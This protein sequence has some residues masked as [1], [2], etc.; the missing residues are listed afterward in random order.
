MAGLP[1]EYRHEPALGLSGGE[2]GL[3]LVLRILRE[4]RRHLTDQGILIVEVGNSEPA[5]I[6]ILPQVP[7]T[8]LEFERGG[9][10]VFLLDAAQ[11]QAH[12]ADFD[13]LVG[14]D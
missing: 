5:L 4:A 14:S 13:A 8:W 10:G 12:Q 7:F 2:T 9:Q 1:L 3:D 6:E 11:L